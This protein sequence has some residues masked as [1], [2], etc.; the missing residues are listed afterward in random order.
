MCNELL[1]AAFNRTK[2]WASKMRRRLEKAGFCAYERRFSWATNEEAQVARLI[3]YGDRY[4]EVKKA[5]KY[6]KEHVSACTLVTG[7]EFRSP[8]R[9]KL[10]KS[11]LE[12][13]AMRK[14]RAA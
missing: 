14:G 2:T 7:L 3:G 1:G 4:I 13:Y 12:A 8:Y 9:G 5:G 6:L 11:G 10:G